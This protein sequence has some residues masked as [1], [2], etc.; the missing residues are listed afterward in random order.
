MSIVQFQFFLCLTHMICLCIRHATVIPFSEKMKQLAKDVY[1]FVTEVYKDDSTCL[2]ISEFNTCTILLYYGDA[3]LAPHRDQLYR[4]DGSLDP[5]RNSQEVNSPTV[6]LSLGDPR[7]M[8][9]FLCTDGRGGNDSMDAIKV[10]SIELD[11]DSM[12][13]LHPCDEKPRLRAIFHK[14][15][16]LVTY[17]KHGG[18]RHKPGDGFSAAF[19][20]RKVNCFKKYFPDGLIYY[21][22]QRLPEE[23]IKR[24]DELDEL[25][26]NLSDEDLANFSISLK[27]PYMEMKERHSQK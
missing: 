25:I 21:D 15:Q 10:D 3:S 2:D 22:E 23:E 1:N 24:L 6:V 14:L 18:V 13:V 7:I 11:H 27:T 17:F 9:F 4:T 5:G 20:F 16:H 8:N 12:F 19:A 26:A